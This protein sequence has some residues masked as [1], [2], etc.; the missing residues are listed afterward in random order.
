MMERQ[1]KQLI[2]VL[3]KE[4]VIYAGIVKVIKKNGE[5]IIYSRNNIYEDGNHGEVSVKTESNDY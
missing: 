4:D 2:F 5:S 1:V 3:S